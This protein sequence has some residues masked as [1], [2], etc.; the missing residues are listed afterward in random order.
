MIEQ[1]KYAIFDMDGTL[2]DSMKYW[3]NLGRNYLIANGIT[4]PDDLEKHLEAQT[5]EQA[6][7]YFIEELG[8]KKT[9][10]VIL[11]ELDEQMAKNYREDVSCKKGAREYLESLKKKGVRMCVA[12]ATP[13]RLAMPALTRLGLDG[14]F[15]FFLDTLEAGLSKRNP[16]IYDLSAARLGGNRENTVVFEDAAYAMRCAFQAGYYT[17]GIRDEYAKILP[18]ELPG[19]C[20]EYWESYPEEGEKR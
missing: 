11:Q 10:P 14:Y 2:L 7:A 19:L 12:S 16:E 3:R 17:V 15:E 13:A 9:V 6:A 20:Q 4:P 18:E 1:M 5:L 8:L